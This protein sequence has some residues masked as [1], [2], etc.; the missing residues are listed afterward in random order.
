MASSIQVLT[1]RLNDTLWGINIL[2]IRENIQNVQPTSV[3]LTPS[4]VAGL[5]NLRG[6]IVTVLDLKHR[7]GHQTPATKDS[8]KDSKN[9]FCIILNTDQDL[10]KY[11]EL[12]D[13]ALPIVYVGTD[14]LGLLTDEV[15][16]VVAFSTDDIRT[17]PAKGDN[18]LE[19]YIYGVV[20]LEDD[21]LLLLDLHKVLSHDT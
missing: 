7:L 3:P 11:E 18:A 2:Q 6:Q 12:A 4:Y 9:T 19:E 8:D 5:I 1:F 14:P 16:D 17:P 10:E 13:P 21:I 15:K 20:T